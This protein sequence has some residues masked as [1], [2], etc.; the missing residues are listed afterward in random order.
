[1]QYC[2]IH[3]LK[4]LKIL[5]FWN[6]LQYF[7]G[8]IVFSVRE[9]IYVSIVI[10]FYLW[11][12]FDRGIPVIPMSRIYHSNDKCIDKCRKNP[13][14][15]TR[16]IHSKNTASIVWYGIFSEVWNS[17]ANISRVNV[18]KYFYNPL[19]TGDCF[20]N[21]HAA[22]CLW[23][24]TT[25]SKEEIFLQNFLE[26]LNLKNIFPRYCMYSKLVNR[27]KSLTTQNLFLWPTNYC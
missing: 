26:I 3:R 17:E 27:L 12:N 24:I 25:I 14:K 18:I 13:G 9:S 23:F 22:N 11:C 5:F 1:M 10:S 8:L 20:Y 6:L 21:V 7:Y 15:N 2:V 4:D 19:Q 16:N